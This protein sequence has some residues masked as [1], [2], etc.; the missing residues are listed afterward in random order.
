MKMMLALAVLLFATAAFTQTA[1]VLYGDAHPVALPSHPEHASVH[2][3]ATPTYI[4][5]GGGV[6]F[7]RG[8][9]PLWQVAGERDEMPLGDVARLLRKEREQKKKA[10]KVFSDQL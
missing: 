5:G 3:M 7:A 8:V 4:L 2:A 6:E 10:E 1:P 9:R